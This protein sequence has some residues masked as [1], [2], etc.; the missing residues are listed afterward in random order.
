LRSRYI[1]SRIFAIDVGLR[2]A[3]V[4]LVRSGA[5]H[6]LRAWLH[7][8]AGCLDAGAGLRQERRRQVLG[9]AAQIL[10]LLE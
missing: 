4:I 6:E 5:H 7:D 8:P 3:F 2:I 10:E 9:A 1:L